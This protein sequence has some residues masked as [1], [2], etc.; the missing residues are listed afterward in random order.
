VVF[1]NGTRKLR[2]FLRDKYSIKEEVLSNIFYGKEAQL[3]RIG[4]LSSS[5]F[6]DFIG[7]VQFRKGLF[8]DKNEISNYWHNSFT[9][10]DG[11]FNLL[12]RLH[13]NYEL[14]IV[15]GN[16]QERITFLEDKYKFRKY[17]DWEV[18]SF[19]VGV[20][21]PDIKIYKE[22]F[23]LTKADASNCLYIDD[24]DIFIKPAQRLGMRTILFKETQKFLED[25]DK[26]G[27]V[28]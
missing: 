6:W 9:P 25:L 23:K 7:S 15:S 20:N 17:F 16:I 26:L 2:K 14:G 4:I 11:I 24:K 3:F 27:I 12:E 1:E 28:V 19:N 13:R 8:I 22:V 21:K 10:R 18:Y 5:D